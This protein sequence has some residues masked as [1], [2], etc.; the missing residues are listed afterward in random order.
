MSEAL[1]VTVIHVVTKC[2]EC[3][4]SVRVERLQAISEADAIA[5]G[6]VTEEVVSG[7]D[8]SLI[9]V[10]SEVPHPKGGL[11]G[12][13][14]ARDW[15]ADLWESIHGPRIRRRRAKGKPVDRD[16]PVS[17]GAWDAN[18]FVWVV[19]FRRVKP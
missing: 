17:G 16:P 14:C 18:P 4:H 19:E 5:E 3:P 15:Y 6:C 9:H 7:Y 12:W 8:G 11:Q 13:D 2:S 1:H 10:P